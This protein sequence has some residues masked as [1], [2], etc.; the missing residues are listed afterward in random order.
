MRS[1][2]KIL[3]LTLRNKGLLKIK[4]TRM[5]G[6]NKQ[7]ALL[8]LKIDRKYSSFYKITN[9]WVLSVSV[10]A[11]KKNNGPTQCH[12][13]QLFGHVQ[14]F[15]TAEF[16]CMKCAGAHSTHE[17]TKPKTFAAKCA[18]CLRSHTC[19]Y[20]RCPNRSATTQTPKTGKKWARIPK[21]PPQR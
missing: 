12:R 15:C 17:S 10:E 4:I 21:L 3:A 19:N 2:K 5:H 20:H 1:T 16:K 7:P 11:L 13:C 14:R 9:C 6:K 8:V 18:N